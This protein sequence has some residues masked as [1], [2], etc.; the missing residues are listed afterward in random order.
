MLTIH[1][2]T[3]TDNLKNNIYHVNYMLPSISL[4]YS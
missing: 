4:T 1:Q 2:T 3:N